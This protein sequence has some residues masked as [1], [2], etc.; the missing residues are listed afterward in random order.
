VQL[1][2][3]VAQGLLILNG[4]VRQDKVD[5]LRESYIRASAAPDTLQLQDQ[6]IVLKETSWWDQ[7]T[8]LLDRGLIR[9]LPP[10][11]LVTAPGK[12]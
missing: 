7:L 11:D 12:L 10:K 9:A 5:L 2:K 1:L 4:I 3:T 8:P 6:L